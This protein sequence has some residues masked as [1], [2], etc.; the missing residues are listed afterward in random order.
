MSPSSDEFFD[1]DFVK[2]NKVGMCEEIVAETVAK[3]SNLFPDVLS[4]FCLISTGVVEVPVDCLLAHGGV[5][6]LAAQRKQVV[7]LQH[8]GHIPES[9]EQVPGVSVL[10]PSSVKSVFIAVLQQTLHSHRW[11]I[12]DL[13]LAWLS[14]GRSL[15]EK[16]EF[17]FVLLVMTGHTLL[18]RGNLVFP[19]HSPGERRADGRQDLRS[20]ELVCV[21]EMKYFSCWTLLNLSHN[22]LLRRLSPTPGAVSGCDGEVR[23]VGVVKQMV[24]PLPHRLSTDLP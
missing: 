1:R 9:P 5:Q 6:G 8:L 21:P 18:K 22:E 2:E 14:V 15:W 16:I 11:N 19:D 12:L 24:H 10:K 17:E 3:F 4:S 20:R 23:H 7:H 13:Q